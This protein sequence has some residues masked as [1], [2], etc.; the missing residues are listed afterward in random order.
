MGFSWEAMDVRK[1]TG[2]AQLADSLLA[3][4]D[5]PLCIAPSVL[6]QEFVTFDTEIRFYFATPN[7]GWDAGGC[8]PIESKPDHIL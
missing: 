4:V 3:L 5:Q 1:F 6:V 8:K 2:E 7:A